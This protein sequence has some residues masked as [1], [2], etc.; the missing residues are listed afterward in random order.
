MSR[1][2]QIFDLLSESIDWLVTRLVFILIAGMVLVTTS[3][4]VFRVFFTA[5]SWS[6][7]LSRYLL[8]WGTFFGATMAY[9]RGNHI[10][11]TFVVEAFGSKMK[12]IFSIIIYILSMIFFGFVIYYGWQMIKM[13]VFQISPAL[14]LPMQ[15]VYLSIPISLFIMIIHA[16]AG[17][18]K[19]FTGLV[20]GGEL[21]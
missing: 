16:L 4:V 18:T 15:Y 17:I 20:N 19:E 7:E 3:Q 13:Q 12:K 2:V 14:S 8:V 11:L 21:K 9:K 10:A 1:V 6:E 5:L